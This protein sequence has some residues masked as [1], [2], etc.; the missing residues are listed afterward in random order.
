MKQG[1]QHRITSRSGVI[2]VVVVWILF[3]LMILAIGLAR[4]TSIEIAL[5]NYSLGQL[6]AKYM[7]WAGVFYA[8]NLIRKDTADK[9][10]S[11]F[12]T[13]YQCAVSFDP[14][15]FPPLG[16]EKIFKNIPLE[17]GYFCISYRIKN[18]GSD[19]NS[20]QIKEWYGLSDE[21][22]KINLNALTPENYII[23]R[24]LLINLG[25]DDSIAET[26]SASVMDW[27][28]TDEEVTDS[29]FGAEDSFYQGLKRAYHCKNLPFDNV[30]ELLLVRGMTLE[31]F[32]KIKDYVTVFPKD[33]TTLLINLNT[34][35]GVVIQSVAESMSGSVTNT[36]LSDAKSL[37]DKIVAYRAG[38][39]GQIMT[40]DDRII[41]LND[42]GL[43]PKE[44]SI[45]LSFQK[46][47]TKISRYIRI[48]TKGTDGSTKAQSKI[49]A[50]IDRTNLSILSWRRD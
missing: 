44:T 7:A 25:V 23:L 13:L 47:V 39:D 22:R 35:S 26:I 11:Q 14:N 27:K 28:D 33:A 41:E 29:G 4:M 38:Q 34:A 21:E 2:L 1:T 8:M 48:I 19:S 5:T 50:V 18:L 42:L 43:N 32:E 20:N 46:Y 36:D 15:D 30:E 9:T 10:T 45:F 17:E 12:D 40:K 24:R 3:I 37:S 31:I 6:R 49:E 16:E